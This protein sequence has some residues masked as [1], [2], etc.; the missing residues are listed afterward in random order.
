MKPLPVPVTLRPIDQPTGARLVPAVPRAAGGPHVDL[1]LS[2]LEPGVVTIDP[3]PF[4][5]DGLSVGV[6]AR[7]I[8]DKPLDSAEAAAGAFWD[9]AAEQLCATLV[10]STAL[11]ASRA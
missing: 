3:Y 4:A 1:T 10:P 11:G 9:C 7:F 5:R 8:D 2:V 6:P